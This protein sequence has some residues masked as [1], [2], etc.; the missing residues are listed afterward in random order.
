MND[1]CV[2]SG[3][4]MP[5]YPANAQG[6]SANAD[7]CKT[8]VESSLMPV[9][10]LVPHIGYKA[11]ADIAMEASQSGRTIRDIVA[12]RQLFSPEQLDS[13]LNLTEM[14]RSNRSK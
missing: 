10:A 7:R 3:P 5:G 8:L 9:T 2:S 14:A 11:A 1:R 4:E 13:L 12:E 6:I